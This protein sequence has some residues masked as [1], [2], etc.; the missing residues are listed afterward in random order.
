MRTFVYRCS[1]ESAL[2]PRPVHLRK[3]AQ[4]AEIVHPESLI[5]LN[6][7]YTGRDRPPLWINHEG[8][9]YR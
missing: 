6:T 5:E 8:E 3:P 7:H 1:Q 9:W 2:K 4:I